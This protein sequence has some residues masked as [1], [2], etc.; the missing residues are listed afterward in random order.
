MVQ[1]A[2]AF[3][4]ARRD[5]FTEPNL[6]TPAALAQFI[7]LVVAFG[8]SIYAF[9]TSDVSVEVE[10]TAFALPWR[11]DNSMFPGRR[12][13]FGLVQP[14][15]SV[16]R[17]RGRH[18]RRK[19]VTSDMGLTYRQS[20]TVFPATVELIKSAVAVCTRMLFDILVPEC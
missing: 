8:S 2:T 12:Q 6:A 9:V 16:C 1:S 18:C 13:I 17:P 14:L 7:V 5:D 3:V 20:Q 10:V 15:L 4:A 11:R 19:F